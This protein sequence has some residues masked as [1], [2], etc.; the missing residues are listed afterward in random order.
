MEI[1]LGF[2]DQDLIMFQNRWK[3]LPDVLMQKEFLTKNSLV[4]EIKNRIGTR[5]TAL[6]PQ[7]ICM[8]YR[9]KIR[10]M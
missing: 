9:K 1:N 2:K 4:C 7:E 6:F 10:Q 3:K 5:Y 8:F